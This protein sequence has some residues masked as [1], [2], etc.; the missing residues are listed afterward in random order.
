[1]K[2]PYCPTLDTN[3]DHLV[4]PVTRARSRRGPYNKPT[5]IDSKVKWY[6]WDEYQRKK[7]S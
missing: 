5:T 3:G 2:N 1:M 6:T 4:P 7:K